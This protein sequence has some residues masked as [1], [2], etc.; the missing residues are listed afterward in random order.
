[1]KIIIEE[2]QPGEEDQIIIRCNELD[3]KL[4]KL[5]YNI[6]MYQKKLAGTKDGNTCLLD[7]AQVYYFEAVENKV[8]IYCKD[9][10]YETKQKLYEIEELYA[11]T[12]F[13]RASKSMIVNV[14]KI[15]QV[16]SAFQGRLE[17]TLKNGEK[18]IISRQYVPELKKKLGLS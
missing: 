3:E 10:Y 5:I 11:N 4:L 8:F 12:N 1:M 2:P 17:A 9:S 13:I 14:S 15:F 6:K 18:L 7:P 16:S